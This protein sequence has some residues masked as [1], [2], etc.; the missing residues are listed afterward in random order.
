MRQLCN[1]FHFYSKISW[2]IVSCFLF[3]VLQIV[4][5]QFIHLFWLTFFLVFWILS[6]LSVKALTWLLSHALRH[7]FLTLNKYEFGWSKNFVELNSIKLF[8][9]QGYFANIFEEWKNIFILVLQDR[10]QLPII[11]KGNLLILII[12]NSNFFLK[13]FFRAPYPLPPLLIFLLPLTISKN[14]FVF[15]IFR[16]ISVAIRI[17][18][19]FVVKVLQLL[20]LLSWTRTVLLIA[21]DN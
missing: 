3:I 7:P 13:H 12:F 17:T 10:W 20:R 19:V 21:G 15:F 11:C 8:I 2:D 4:D 9:F 5:K 1:V 6:W 18:P 16:K 14:C